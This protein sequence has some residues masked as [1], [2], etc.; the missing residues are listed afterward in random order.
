MDLNKNILWVTQTN[1]D[2]M[3]EGI[4]RGCDYQ[5]EGITRGHLG[6]GYH[7]VHASNLKLFSSHIKKFKKRKAGINFNDTFYLPNISK[8][9]NNINISN[10]KLFCILFY[11]KFEF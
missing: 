11:T 4:T 8:Y 7:S 1:A 10:I 5:E 9:Y 6:D 2:T 3:W